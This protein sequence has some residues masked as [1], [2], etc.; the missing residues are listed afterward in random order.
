M[1]YFLAESKN[2]PKNLV[3][4]QEGKFLKEKRD[5]LQMILLYPWKNDLY[6][7]NAKVFYSHSYKHQ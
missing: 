6:F 4:K 5:N 2:K 7:K 1:R 3:C